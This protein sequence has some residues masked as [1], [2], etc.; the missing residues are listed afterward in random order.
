[1]LTCNGPVKLSPANYQSLII[2]GGWDDGSL[3]IATELLATER[4]QV[5]L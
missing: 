1:M 5:T 3:P 2:D 4:F